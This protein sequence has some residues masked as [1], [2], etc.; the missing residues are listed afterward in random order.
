MIPGRARL[1]LLVLAVF[2]LHDAV[3]RNFRVDGIRPDL[4]L[5]LTVVA[6]V[7]GGPERG[8]IAG[9][10]GGF[11]IDLFLATPLGLTSLVWCALGYVVGTLQVTILPHGRAAIPVT[12]FVASA[13]GEVAFAL[14]ASMLGQPG[15]TNSHLLTVALI[16]AVVNSLVSVP[17]ARAVR[18][19]VAGNPGERAYA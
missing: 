14:A 9:F 7:V 17:L 2:Y 1:P 12:A 8:A 13:A 11:V 6:A 19:A 18:W 15:M 3:L 16:V 5:G 10:L 4:L